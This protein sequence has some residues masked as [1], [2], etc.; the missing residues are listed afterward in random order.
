MD[1]HPGSI[2]LRHSSAV[3]VP[4]VIW[5]F[6]AFV[7]GDALVEGSVGYAIR[8]A[9]LMSAVAFIVFATLAK[10]ALIVDDEGITVANVLRTHR[11]PFGA[12]VD[13]RVGGLTSLVA[14]SARGD[15]TITSW[16]GPGIRR[17]PR[18]GESEVERLIRNRWE[19]WTRTSRPESDRAMLVSSW[20]IRTFAVVLGLI[21]LNIAI[22]LR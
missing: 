15:R 10:P 2:S 21:A 4:A 20:N 16:N 3:W 13:V 6:C 17:V 19:T 12:L 14:R 7:L 11:I 5:V 9:L 22:R 8:V 18:L 1:K